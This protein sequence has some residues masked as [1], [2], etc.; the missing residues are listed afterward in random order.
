M[1]VQ[2]LDVDED[3]LGGAGLDE[4]DGV[5]AVQGC[6]DVLIEKDRLELVPKDGPDDGVVVN[7]QDRS[8]H[9]ELL[10]YAATQ[11]GTDCVWA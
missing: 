2:G 4:K 10:A 6:D 9:R 11:N 1:C 7:E 5:G 3:D 8:A